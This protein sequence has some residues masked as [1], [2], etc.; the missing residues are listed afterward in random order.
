MA[1]T[2]SAKY[3]PHIMLD[4]V[5]PAKEGRSSIWKSCLYSMLLSEVIFFLSFFWTAYRDIYV[6]SQFTGE[7]I[8]DWISVL[9]CLLFLISM[10]VVFAV[11]YNIAGDQ[12]TLDYTIAHLQFKIRIHKG[13]ESF[14]KYG[15]NQELS[16]NIF[17]RILAALIRFILRRF[18]FYANPRDVIIS[19]TGIKNFN[20]DTGLTTENLNES[21]WA[22]DHPYMG[23]HGFNL[24][25]VSNIADTD[26]VI[27]AN[28]L[29][30]M[31]TLGPDHLVSTTMISGHNT[32]YIMDDVE[33]QLKLPN[34]SP[35]REKAL[36]SIYNKFKNRVGTEEPLFIIHIGL[37]PAVHEYEHIENM[38]KVR[39]EFELTLNE[40][41]I[42][43]VLIKDPE[44]LAYIIN[45]M[46]TGNL[47]MGKDINEY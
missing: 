45:G 46:F 21:T 33:E 35:V 26:E 3:E 15:T 31:S 23:D 34:L 6:F 10:V 20:R 40:I 19:F 43:T 47:V 1:E 7:Y 38:R 11:W 14:S 37:P 18:H 27:I 13:L 22:L 42:D 8:I 25:A 24:L 41:G 16:G 44:D 9:K 39:D 32:S 17:K 2:S 29:E 36:W 12:K 5:D 30:A 4:I 28:F